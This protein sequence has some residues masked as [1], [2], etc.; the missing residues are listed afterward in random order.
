MVYQFPMR[1][2]T[3]IVIF[4]KQEA[5]EHNV[6]LLLVLFCVNKFATEQKLH[7]IARVS[8]VIAVPKWYTFDNIF[9][10]VM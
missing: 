9:Q 1:T 7:S 10:E 3:K 8:L 4:P 6:L 2:I 5:E